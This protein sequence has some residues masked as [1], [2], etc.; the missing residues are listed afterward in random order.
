MTLVTYTLDRPL[1]GAALSA[2]AHGA[3][4]VLGDAAR[5]RIAVAHDLVRAIVARGTPA[6]GVNTGVGALFD[7]AV[8]PALHRRLSRQLV[9]SHACGVGA[10]LSEAEV[11]AIIA[12]QANNHAHGHSGVRVAVVE[13]LLALLA[14]RIVPEVPGAGSVGYLT[15]MAHIALVL[16]GEGHARIGDQDQGG[17]RLTGAQALARAGLSPLVLDAK[18]GLSLLNGAPCATGLG[19]VAWARA[20]RAVVAADGVAALSFECL[21]GNPAA[22][23]PGVLALRRSAGVAQTGAALN[24]WLAGSAHLSG[25]ARL[26]DP[27]SL[28]SIPQ[29]HGGVRDALAY[30][31]TMIDDELASVTD[32][33]VM[34]G[35]T[36]APR[37]C[38]A[39][40]AIATGLAIA[41][42]ALGVAIAHIGMM[43]ERRTDRMVNPLV[44]GLP[45][46]LAAEAGVSSGFMIA[47]YTASALVSENRRLAAPAS[48]DGGI[49]SGLQEDYLSHPTAAAMKA[50]AIVANVEAI[51]GIE[52]AAA[53]QA[54][55][56][57]VAPD[58]R[59]PATAKLHAH[60][61]AAIAPFADDRP[62][63]EVI[64]Q[65]ADLVRAGLPLPA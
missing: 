1:D 37:A 45:P 59:A 9:M 28:R 65:G 27:L 12:A 25:A 10:P 33:P 56:L 48:L 53:A 20:A 16:I 19:A 41:L 47:Q 8:E 44:S 11:R 61:R 34:L 17:Q 24:A 49:T 23:V 40:Q 26:Q 13:A 55:D 15:H 30:V 54:H 36:E 46:F 2:V 43:S 62:M 39:A 38:S 21:G 22:F 35:T 32:N 18:E 63:N 60:V 14:H 5:G 52:L 3:P 6:Y 31:G 4:L 42:D 51:L 57:G 64:E 58:A 50:L 7:R 29:V